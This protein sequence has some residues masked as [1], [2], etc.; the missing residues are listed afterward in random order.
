M[1]FCCKI[2][3]RQIA[4]GRYFIHEHPLTATSWAT[5]CMAQLRACPAVYT[6]EA[7]VCAYGM[8]SKDKHGPGYAK[9]PTRFLTNPIVGESFESEVSRGPQARSPHGGTSQ[10]CGYI[11][12]RTL[13]N[14]LSSDP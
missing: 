8:K 5:E 10:S 9:K 13:Q 2:Y 7:H 3:A 6:A 11:S 14:Y 1:E 12:S 4:V